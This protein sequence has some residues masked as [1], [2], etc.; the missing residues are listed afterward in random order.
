MS[1]HECFFAWLKRGFEVIR[2]LEFIGL[3]TL[4]LRQELL[5]LTR[6]LKT[7]NA[8]CRVICDEG[9][10]YAALL[11]LT[12]Y[13]KDVHRHAEWFD[14]GTRSN[15]IEAQLLDLTRTWKNTQ[16]PL[17]YV[18]TGRWVIFTIESCQLNTKPDGENCIDSDSNRKTGSWSDVMFLDKICLISMDVF[19]KTLYTFDMPLI[20][21]S[22]GFHMAFVWLRYIFWSWYER[23]S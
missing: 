13:F 22:Y 21:L 2:W 20:C 17:G 23:F 18:E 9:S 1:S 15:C 7:C 8:S 11:D 16:P 4:R 5:D 3:D 10:R 19:V 12:T 6:T 14:R